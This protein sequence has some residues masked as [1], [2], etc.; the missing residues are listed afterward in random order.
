M[1]EGRVQQNAHLPARGSLADL[2][3]YT[4]RRRIAF[5]S[6][7]KAGALGGIRPGHGHQ[8]LGEQEAYR[9]DENPGEN[10]R[11]VVV[12]AINCG[13]AHRDEER[14]ENPEQVAAVAPSAE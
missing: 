10:V 11:D 8:S 5:G 13:H 9:A 1:H 4:I 12:T 6:D 3:E 14:Q 7:R 2:G